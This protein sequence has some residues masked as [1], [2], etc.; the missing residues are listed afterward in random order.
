MDLAYEDPSSVK[1][2]HFMKSLYGAVSHEGVK[3]ALENMRF[4][5]IKYINL[6]GNRTS[7]IVFLDTKKGAVYVFHKTLEHFSFN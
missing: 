1:A 5:K 2:L 4:K 6:G 3:E 7:E